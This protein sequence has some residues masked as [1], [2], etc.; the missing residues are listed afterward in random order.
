[1]ILTPS[2]EQIARDSPLDGRLIHPN[3]VER[4]VQLVHDAARDVVKLNILSSCKRK[5]R[6]VQSDQKRLQKAQCRTHS[7]YIQERSISTSLAAL[8]SHL[9]CSS[10]SLCLCR[11]TTRHVDWLICQHQSV[12]RSCAATVLD[13]LR[14]LILVHGGEMA[15]T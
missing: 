10:H 11:S 5:R 8:L 15:S 13:R 4:L 12:S 9:R 14:L 6:L 3:G 7:V 2:L 1:M